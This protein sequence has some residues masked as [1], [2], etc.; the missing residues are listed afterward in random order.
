MLSRQ[1]KRTS[2]L[3]LLALFGAGYLNFFSGL[4]IS[5]FVRGY[6]PLVPVQLVVLVYLAIALQRRH[7]SRH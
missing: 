1:V 5:P 3:L 6:A 4:D 7:K 2:I